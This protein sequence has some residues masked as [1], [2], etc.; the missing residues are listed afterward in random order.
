MTPDYSRSAKLAGIIAASFAIATIAVD[1]VGCTVQGYTGIVF[2]GAAFGAA[3]W[4]SAL[5]DQQQR[6]HAGQ[7][8]AA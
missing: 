8:G 2:A 7:G 6:V 5:H 1:K 4:Y 3:V